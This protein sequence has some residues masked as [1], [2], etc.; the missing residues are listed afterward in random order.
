MGRKIYTDFSEKPLLRR[1]TYQLADPAP[2]EAGG[3]GYQL[4]VEA[5]RQ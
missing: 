2:C 1:R 5:A 4:G 3:V